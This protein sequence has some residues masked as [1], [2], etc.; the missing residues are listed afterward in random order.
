MAGKPLFV[1]G[2]LRDGDLRAAL[3]GRDLPASACTPAQACGF[4]AVHYPQRVYPA[5]V[6]MP[7]G[8][9]PG[10]LLHGL[11]PIDLA[12]LDA[13]EGDEYRRDTIDVQ[14][15]WGPVPAD[16]YLPRIAIAPDAAPWTLRHWAAH[17]SPQ[18]LAGERAA[19]VILR[20]RFTGR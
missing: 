18:V 8:N 1:Y 10:L 4:G 6:A 3:L 9:A 17:H 5:L 20:D 13:F 12:I 15:P 14:A 2:T 11:T 16:T 19:A 7:H